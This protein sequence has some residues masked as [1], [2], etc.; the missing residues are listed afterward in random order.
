MNTQQDRL[1][2]PRTYAFTPRYSVTC[3]LSAAMAAVI[4]LRSRCNLRPPPVVEITVK[5]SRFWR[6]WLHSAVTSHSPICNWLG[7]IAVAGPTHDGFVDTQA[8]AF[9]VSIL[10]RATA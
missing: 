4:A 6:G 8:L 5:R 2:N 3:P 9:K 7:V 10:G 1:S